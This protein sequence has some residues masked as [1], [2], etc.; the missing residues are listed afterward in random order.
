MV[1][2]IYHNV[3]VYLLYRNPTVKDFFRRSRYT[4]CPILLATYFCLA[5]AVEWKYVAALFCSI[6]RPMDLTLFVESTV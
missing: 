4:A 3:Y 5:L 6:L 1:N 2:E